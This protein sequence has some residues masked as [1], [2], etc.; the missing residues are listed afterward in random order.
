MLERMIRCWKCN[1]EKEEGEF[2]WENKALG[3]RKR[4]CRICMKEYHKKWFRQSY[5]NSESRKQSLEWQ[6]EKISRARTYVINYL[7]AHPCV[8][9]GESAP[10]FLDF[11][12]I[13]KKPWDGNSRV[14]RLVNRGYSQH[15]IDEEIA[16]C[17]V[18]CVRCH[19]LKTA[20]EQGWLKYFVS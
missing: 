7:K 16:K 11:D 14:H 2:N 9:C 10:V 5:K 8:Q 6:R 15:R 3:K 13:D 1:T 18:L 19:R 4:I 20:E 17:Q 12:H